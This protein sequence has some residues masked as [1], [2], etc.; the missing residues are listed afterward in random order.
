MPG[1][2]KNPKNPY[3]PAVDAL[4]SFNLLV[5]LEYIEHRGGPSTLASLSIGKIPGLL[6]VINYINHERSINNLPPDVFDFFYIDRTNVLTEISEDTQALIYILEDSED[7]ADAASH[8]FPGYIQEDSSADPESLDGTPTLQAM[9]AA[10][11]L[12]AYP[13]EDETA[14]ELQ[15]IPVTSAWSL[16]AVFFGFGPWNGPQALFSL[17]LGSDANPFY[18]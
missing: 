10:G 18:L 14:S 15:P 1:N 9:N 11:P 6:A 2:A 4:S 16:P 7:N 12:S 3:T 17:F 13:E 5:I 8:E